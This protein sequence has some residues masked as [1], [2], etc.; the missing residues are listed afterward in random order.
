MNRSSSIFIWLAAFFGFLLPPVN[1]QVNLKA[2]YNI[3]LADPGLNQVV[4]AFSSSQNYTSPFN[5][6]SWM[7]GF[8]AGL[9]FKA[10]I[11]AFEVTYQNAYQRLQ[12]KGDHNDGTGPYSDKI[13]LGIQSGAIGYQVTGEVFGMGTDLQYQW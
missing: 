1:A 13:R 7:H 10:D 2:G 4:K 5:Q 9:R 3:S 11:H 6:L 8:E 12:A